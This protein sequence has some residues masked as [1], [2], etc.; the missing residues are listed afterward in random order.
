MLVFSAKTI[1]YSF[2]SVKKVDTFS[3]N[4]DPVF[5]KYQARFDV[6][7]FFFVNALAICK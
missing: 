5:S 1:I 4:D 7:G 3:V 6:F 2:I